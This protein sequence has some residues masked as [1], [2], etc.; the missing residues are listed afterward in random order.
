MEKLK[1][2]DNHK[3]FSKIIGTGSYLPEKV[4]TNDDLAKIVDT[5]DEWIIKRTGIKTRHIARDDE[6]TS[7]LAAAAGKKALEA[8]GVEPGDIDCIIVGTTTPDM[9]FP[10]TG[11]LVQD[12]LGIPDAPAFDLSAA[13]SGMIYSLSVADAYIRSGL[14]KTVLVIGA[15]ALSKMLDFEDRSTCVLFGDGA[16]AFVL[17]A[18]SEPGIECMVLGA[19]G[20][21]SGILEIPAGGSRIPAS[22]ESVDQR[23]HSVKAN[24]R[25]VFK[26]AVRVM[27]EKVAQVMQQQGLTPDDI[28]LLVPHQANYRIIDAGRQRL[29]LSW[30]KVMVNVDKYG[31]TTAGT[32]PIAVDE[33]IRSGRV[34]K[35]DR[36]LMVSFGAGFTWGISIARL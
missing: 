36:I 8:A 29:G 30:D 1:E 13:C 32:I 6:P 9:F 19:D 11:C 31:N 33:A 25:E 4:L 27:E 20:S 14:Y 18:A 35:G 3:V 23:L 26:L 15:D 5:T 12:L 17:Q 24:G 10:A 22:H 16:G 21:Q 34:K 28:Q 2:V 7:E